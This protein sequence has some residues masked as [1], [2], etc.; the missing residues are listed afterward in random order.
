MTEATFDL[1]EYQ[2]A[3]F[4]NL[5]AWKARE[6]IL[7]PTSAGG[8]PIHLHRYAK[9]GV[10]PEF[11]QEINQL[12]TTYSGVQGIILNDEPTLPRMQVTAEAIDWV[13]STFPDVL[14]Y[15]NAFPIGAPSE[16]YSGDRELDYSYSQYIEDYV[17][18]VHPDVVMFDIYPFGDGS[19]DVSDLYYQN[20]AMVRDVALR[21]NL[22]YWAFI[23]SYQADNR[24][25]PS[26]SDMRMQ[27]YSALTYGYTGLAYFTYDVAFERG[28]LEPDGSPN[29]LYQQAAKLNGEVLRIGDSLRT[30]TSTDV[31]FVPGSTQETLPAGTQL[32]QRGAGN[33][34]TIV[35]ITAEN[36]GAN[37]QIG[38]IGFFKDDAGKDY[39]MLT[40]L[41]H[42]AGLSAEQ[43]TQ[44]FQIGFDPLLKNIYRMSRETGNIESLSLSNTGE[45]ELKLPGGTGDLFMYDA[46]PSK[47][48]SSLGNLK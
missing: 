7:A 31:R 12:M 23:Q 34:S 24:R 38:L 27:V 5:L 6:G 30:L 32:W 33:N 42:D 10:S 37:R 13:R 47:P 44:T 29:S 9:N 14:V 4:N 18:L 41:W 35:S 36:S 17:R 15:S 26:E 20:M 48:T 45:V 21:D 40:N 43:A 16:E 3:G 8:L 46:V 11:R 28:L 19:G 22:P 25:H 2:Q 39:F 1:A